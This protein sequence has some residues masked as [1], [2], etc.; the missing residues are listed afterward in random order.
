MK[1][2]P[3]LSL[4]GLA[5]LAI[6]CHKDAAPPAPSPSPLLP[7]AVQFQFGAGASPVAI[8]STT[9]VLRNLPAGVDAQKLAATAVLPS[10]YTISPDPSVAADYTK[11]VTFKLTGSQ[12]SYNIKLTAM[13]Y[14]SLA[15]PYGIYTVKDLSNVRH[16]LTGYFIL[17]NDI[18]L[19]SAS[20]ANA[21][22]LTG[23]SDYGSYGWYSIGSRYVNGGHIVFR[24]S[25]DGQNHLIKNLNIAY[26]DGGVP[27]PDGIDTVVH[28]GKGY[29]G[30][31]GYAV[32]ARFKNIGI[33]LAGGIVGTGSDGSRVMGSLVGLA[34][35]CTISNCYV[36]GAGSLSGG[37]STGG[38]IGTLRTSNIS[39]C[40]ASITHTP[41]TF[42]ISNG[43]G[44]IGDAYFSTISA[45]SAVCDI[46][47]NAN[48]G[49]LVGYVSTCSIRNS[50]ASGTVVESPSN[51]GA[52]IP[53]DA[54]G[55]LIGTVT[56]VNSV[57]PS[58][59]LINNCY[60]IVN[61]TGA[62]GGDATYLGSTYIGGLVGS[63]SQNAS[64]VTVSNC[65]AAGAVTR[66]FTNSNPATPMIGG[67]AGNTFN[68]VFAAA[69]GA[70]TNY[71][72]KTTS[73]QSLL[74]G[75]NASIAPD[76]GITANGMT[77]TQMK[78]QTT[79]AGWDFTTTWGIDQSKN[80]GYPYLR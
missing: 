19:P 80:N 17:M 30:L 64:K 46:T 26:R 29:D 27:M 31:F 5:T 2:R 60:A 49:G 44:L 3:L 25:I 52:L 51:G 65:F 34:D 40:Y 70:C 38:L 1:L 45:C 18:A 74:G 37:G 58:S 6:A 28:S 61:V 10:G 56:S 67:L 75:G 78:T 54:I 9:K 77:T 43:G 42:S 16:Y 35:T 41:G 62:S 66:T 48:L 24:G 68:G 21:A 69:G 36:T 63:I 76:N 59:T 20:D 55:G 33:Q 79:Y 32:G 57:A 72:D 12:G 14:D 7:V 4:I 71:W 53:S 39:K 50:Y 8:D 22:T 13:P 15:N 73:T 23:I 11:G 47:G